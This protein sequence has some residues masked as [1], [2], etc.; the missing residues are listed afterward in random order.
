MT[1]FL[2][3]ALGTATWLLATAFILCLCRA[4]GQADR[5]GFASGQLVGRESNVVD[6]GAFRASRTD[7]SHGSTSAARRRPAA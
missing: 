2:V 6:L 3:A 1:W 5:C 7:P 4:A